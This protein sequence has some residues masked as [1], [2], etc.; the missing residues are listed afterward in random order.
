M[1]RLLSSLAALC[2]AMS[3]AHAQTQTYHFNEGGTAPTGAAA[4]PAPAATSAAAA[5]AQARTHHAKPHRA[6]SHRTHHR[7]HHRARGL[8]NDSFYSHP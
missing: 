5:P 6:H 1:K 3:A 2:V 4:Q 7:K 8:R